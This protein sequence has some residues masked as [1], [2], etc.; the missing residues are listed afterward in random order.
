M[1][2]RKFKNS[3]SSDWIF[4]KPDAVFCMVNHFMR[5]L[6]IAIFLFL[7]FAG[8]TQIKVGARG[9]INLANFVY[10]PA[11]DG[12]TKG[13]G[14]YLFRVNGGLQLEIPLNDND[15]WFLF[16]GP[17]NSGKGDRVRARYRTPEFDTIV[18]YLNY[19]ELPLSVGYKFSQGNNNRF[20]AAAGPYAAC[21]FGGKV[22]YHNDPV[23]TKRNLHRSDGWYKRID[24]GFA[25]NVMYEIKEK[26]GI[27]LDY[28]RS[29]SDIS[30]SLYEWKENNNVF[31]FSFFWYFKKKKEIED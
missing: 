27:R 18:T 3:L 28:S 11:Y 4:I 25:V 15:N 22:V 26:W 1:G 29:I 10:R 2:K 12:D 20:I 17:F 14:A 16:S 6:L 8:K 7:S 24:I 21:G 5:R 13:A 23:H 19:I 31:G 9:G 30:K